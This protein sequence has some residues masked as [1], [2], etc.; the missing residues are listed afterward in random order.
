MYICYFDESGDDGY[1][2]YS[3]QLFVLSSLYMHQ[4]S[5][6]ENYEKIRAFR[7]QLKIDYE[8]PVK[9]EFH[10]MHFLSDKDPYHGKYS[11][12]ERKEI[13][14]LFCELI[15]AL[16]IKCINVVIDKGR[17]QRADYDVL[18]NALTY[19]IQRIENDMNYS[20][21]SDKDFLILSD[22]GRVASMRRVT[23]KIQRINFIPSKH[24]HGS[25]RKEIEHL[26]EDPLPKPSE[27]SYFIQMADL[28]ASTT[29]LYA[30]RNL[31]NPRISWANRLLNVLD[32]GDEL[33]ML[34]IMKPSLNTKASGRDDY[35]VVYYPI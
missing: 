5:W 30:R 33:E 17:I 28:L 18:E 14:F 34:N 22:E 20:Q 12:A 24:H 26:I 25:Y 9:M 4:S 21:L 35:G 32:Y 19:N 7:K 10:T 8:F 2:Q 15:A 16:K 31:T 29:M 6:K 23:R 3:S 13:T 11:P 27:E 1:P